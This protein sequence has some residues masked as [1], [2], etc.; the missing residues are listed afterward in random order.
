MSRFMFVACALT[1]GAVSAA[2]CDDRPAASS[3]TPPAAQMREMTPEEIAAATRPATDVPASA[4]SAPSTQPGG[5]AGAATNE[6]PKP[7][8]STSEQLE[9]DADDAAE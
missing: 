4:S 3:G 6:A 2:G 1:V 9:K 5:T 7:P 8:P